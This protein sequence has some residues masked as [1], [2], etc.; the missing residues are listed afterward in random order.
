MDTPAAASVYCITVQGRLDE[1]WATLL[2]G[3]RIET[4]DEHGACVTRLTGEIVDADPVA[5][6]QRIVHLQGEAGH[7]VAERV[8]E[9]E[10]NHRGQHGR[11]R[12]DAGEVEPCSRGESPTIGC[13]WKFEG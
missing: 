2:T 13:S 6:F 5:D 11:G 4:A 12:D 9:R 7:D 1:T 3:L 10:A 8:L